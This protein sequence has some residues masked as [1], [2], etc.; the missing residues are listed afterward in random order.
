MIMIITYTGTKIYPGLNS[1]RVRRSGCWLPL[2]WSCFD[3]HRDHHF[4]DGDHIMT[5]VSMVMMMMVMM[6]AKII[7]QMQFRLNAGCIL[8]T[9]SPF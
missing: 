5:M 9:S 2:A 1:Q 8:I 3:D 4:D 7:F 6:V